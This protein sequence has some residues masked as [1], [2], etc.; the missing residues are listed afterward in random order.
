MIS[1]PENA[2]RTNCILFDNLGKEVK[3]YTVSG[4]ENLVGIEELES[5][6]YL[7]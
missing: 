3:R 6:I 5:G 4:G 1:L 2:S 7:I